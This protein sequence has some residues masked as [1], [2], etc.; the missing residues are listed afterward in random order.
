MGEWE[1]QLK[2]NPQL[3]RVDRTLAMLEF[4][5]FLSPE[6]TSLCEEIIQDREFFLRVA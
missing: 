4:R 5:A 3:S 6:E 2:S 1:K